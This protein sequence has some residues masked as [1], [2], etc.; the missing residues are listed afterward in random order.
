MPPSLRKVSQFVATMNSTGF[1]KNADEK[2]N[3]VHFSDSTVQRCYRSYFGATPNARVVL[4][5]RLR[6]EMSPKARSVHP[7]LALFLSKHYKTELS[8]KILKRFKD[9]TF[10]K[11][12][13]NMLK[14]FPSFC[15]LVIIIHRSLVEVNKNAKNF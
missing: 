12:V 6:K 1:S 2:L 4:W 11:Q 13:W 14:I 10:Q 3:F 7:F 5:S 8:N 9:K 15:L